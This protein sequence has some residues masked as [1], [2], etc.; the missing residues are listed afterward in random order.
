METAT[1]PGTTLPAPGVWEL[2][3]AHTTV[4]FVARHL[5]VAKVRGRFTGV[6][7]SITVAERPEDSSVEVTIDAASI[8]TREEARD[9]H[10]RSPDFLDVENHP[11]ITFRSTRVRH[12][13][14]NRWAV[15]GDLT[16]RGVTR[17]VTLDVE[18]EGLV[19]DPWGGERIG[20]SATAEIDRDDWGVSWNMPLEAGG[21]LV[22]KKVKIEIEVEAV[23]KG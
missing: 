11:A 18:Y 4:G 1:A 9:N 13:E 12:V 7:G 3:P 10:L 20:F 21:L 6:S 19:R 23:R 5:M 17:P 22:G 2:D 8:D 15:D 14:G 16:I